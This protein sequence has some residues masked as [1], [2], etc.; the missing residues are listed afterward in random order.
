MHRM[1]FMAAAAALVAVGGFAVPGHAQA[2][3]G[4]TAFE[5]ARII[6][7]DGRV[8]ENATLVVDGARITQAG[9]AAEVRVPAGAEHVNLAGKTVMP[10]MID[11]HTHLSQTPRSARRATSS[12]A[13]ITA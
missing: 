7:G 9:P 3:S 6:V 8:I 10:T 5:G 11:T 2:P 1:K 12:G 13:R 4:A